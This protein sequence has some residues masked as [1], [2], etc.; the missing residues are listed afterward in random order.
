LNIAWP[1]K[2]SGTTPP[3]AACGGPSSRAS[4]ARNS[5]IGSG[6]MA[7]TPIASGASR[8]SAIWLARANP[9]V[10]IDRGR[11]RLASTRASEALGGA[12]TSALAGR[13]VRG[14]DAQADIAP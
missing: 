2:Q 5:V 6:A 13:L 11:R 10:T 8:P 1:V 12:G 9:R 7:A 3:D 4:P 14:W